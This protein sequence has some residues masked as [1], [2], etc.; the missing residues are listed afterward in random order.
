MLSSGQLSPVLCF[1]LGL[2]ATIFF[3]NFDQEKL[4]AV[5][6]TQLRNV[7]IEDPAYYS[8]VRNSSDSP[9]TS[10]N[11]GA[12]PSSSTR[13]SKASSRSSF[14]PNSSRPEG[15]KAIVQI[16]DVHADEYI[17][18]ILSTHQ[19]LYQEMK[20]PKDI[21]HAVILKGVQDGFLIDDEDTWHLGE[22]LTA[23][24]LIL[25]DLNIT[26]IP[27]RDENVF[28]EIG[29]MVAKTPG[30]VRN[31]FEATFKDGHWKKFLAKIAVFKL[32]MFSRLLFLD[33]DVIVLKP[34]DELFDVPTTPAGA[35]DIASGMVMNTGVLVVDPNLE[36][37]RTMM[38]DIMREN[39][40]PWRSASKGN[41]LI[42]NDQ[43]FINYY[44]ASKI[45]VLDPYWNLLISI[46][47]DQSGAGETSPIKDWGAFVLE[48]GNF[49][50]WCLRFKRN[51]NLLKVV[52]MAYP[53]PTWPM[54]Q[55]GCS[56]N[57]SETWAK[58]STPAWN[59]V[60]Y[61]NCKPGEVAFPTWWRWYAIDSG[62]PGW[63]ILSLMKTFWTRYAVIIKS[64]CSK[65]I[66]RELRPC[67]KPYPH[68]INY[69]M[70]TTSIETTIISNDAI[71]LWHDDLV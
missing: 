6:T 13:M 40:E 63:A 70:T 27:Y 26:V 24:V 43:D 39:P 11:P 41:H 34:V 8:W 7:E 49:I 35:P 45:H 44:F 14:T 69:D 54:F 53:K 50:N 71:K 20:P 25:R 2:S 31:H 51:R 55:K 56:K 59:P 58:L 33:C 12:A 62:P 28:K 10:E 36:L 46:H 18:N 64:I 1:I 30:Q 47:H 19:A 68:W 61:W 15:R 21:E 60:K 42:D 16:L 4:R 3:S 32:T 22:A 29:D 66:G 65:H 38:L 17:Y 5:S 57:D 48:T 9:P 67:R 37:F 52:H 23:S